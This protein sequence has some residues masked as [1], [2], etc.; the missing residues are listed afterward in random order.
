[1][2]PSSVFCFHSLSL[3]TIFSSFG[4]NLLT[5]LRRFEVGDD[6]CLLITLRPGQIWQIISF[7]ISP[8]KKNL[9][10]RDLAST[11]EVHVLV[12]PPFTNWN[13]LR[14]GW[15]ENNKTWNGH[16]NNLKNIHVQGWFI[17]L[18]Q[19]I[20]KSTNN[21]LCIIHI[22]LQTFLFCLVQLVKDL[23][24][25]CMTSPHMSQQVRGWSL[26]MLSN[27]L[28][29]RTKLADHIILILTLTKGFAD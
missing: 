16:S 26:R 21:L 14:F 12:V 4:W 1:M 17:K 2:I 6:W 28:G 23:Q 24:L 19:D 11:L 15:T 5:C 29:L 27:H 9:L 8:S 22:H 7:F 10:T 18:Y 20:I 13:R 25:I 3:I